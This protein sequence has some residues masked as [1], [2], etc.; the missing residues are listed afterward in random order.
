MSRAIIF[1]ASFELQ[2]F[3]FIQIFV[4]THSLLYKSDTEST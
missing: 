3:N 1:D 2:E 4:R